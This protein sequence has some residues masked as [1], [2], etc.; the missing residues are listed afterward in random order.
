MTLEFNTIIPAIRGCAKILEENG[1][2]WLY[3]FTDAQSEAYRAY[4]SDFYKKTK[5]SA[6]V[7]L[8][9]I[10]DSESITLCGEATSA[11]SRKFFA[12]DVY[13]DG[14]L[15]SH[16]IDS[17]EGS[18]T[19]YTIRAYLGKGKSKKVCIYFPWSAQTNIASLE[20]DD[21]AS[22]EPCV[23]P[24]KMICFGDSITH[25]YDALNPSFS[26]ASRL[27]DLLRADHINKGIGG[28]VFFPALAEN[29]DLIE[30]D[31]ITVAYGTNDWSHSPKEDFEKNSRLFYEALSK[32]YP[33]AKIFA[34]APVWRENYNTKV[35]PI[36]DFSNVAKTLSEI[37]DSLPNVTFIDCF[38]FI[39]HDR[40]YYVSDV[41][42]P[43]DAGFYHYAAE[44][45][46]AIKG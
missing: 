3:R 32:N 34:L 5:T 15:V 23:R 12:F 40:Q 1:R 17:V 4:S 2:L 28:E 22:F 14:S 43:N 39:P 10:T 30:P 45:Y 46:R 6:G 42:H 25:G 9:F 24:Y 16:F 44:L 29:R 35:T 7:R 37:A 27:S 36:G 13:S 19:P 38:D 8:E 21:G 41:L 33:N 31:F 18:P 20:L 26:Y 11:S